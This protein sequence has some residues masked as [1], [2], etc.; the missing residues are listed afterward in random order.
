[1]FTMQSFSTELQC[2]PRLLYAT[3]YTYLSGIGLSFYSTLKNMLNGYI[4]KNKSR[5]NKFVFEIGS[6]DGTLH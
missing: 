1:M 6:N 5:N 3:N 4:K 2:D